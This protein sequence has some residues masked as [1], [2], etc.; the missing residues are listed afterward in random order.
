MID[1]VLA[2]PFL[3]A[4]QDPMFDPAIGFSEPT[5]GRQELRD[6]LADA[7]VGARP[8]RR[9][10]H[11][12]DSVPP[13]MVACACVSEWKHE[14]G[15]LSLQPQTKVNGDLCKIDL[16]VCHMQNIVYACR[17]MKQVC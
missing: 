14:T 10:Y 17:C 3:E 4:H 1:A 15:V 2:L 6:L 9:Y 11:E 7:R 13:E 12:P 16:C 5:F 8:E